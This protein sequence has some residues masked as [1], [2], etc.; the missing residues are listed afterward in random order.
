MV[1]VCANFPKS[2]SKSNFEVGI[3][4]RVGL[5]FAYVRTREPSTKI[6]RFVLVLGRPVGPALEPFS[7]QSDPTSDAT[8]RSNPG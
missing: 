5:L 1:D 6:A 2:K 4:S 7:T 3:R 8:D